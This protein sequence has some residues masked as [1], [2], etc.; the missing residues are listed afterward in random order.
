MWNILPGFFLQ[1]RRAEVSGQHLEE[2][3]PVSAL[4]DRELLQ[5][6]LSES[7]RQESGPLPEEEEKPGGGEQ[8]AIVPTRDEGRKTG[9][10]KFPSLAS[11][12]EEAETVGG[13]PRGCRQRQNRLREGPALGGRPRR[14]SRLEIQASVGR[15]LPTEESGQDY[16]RGSPGVPRVCRPEGVVGQKGGRCFSVHRSGTEQIQKKAEY[17]RGRTHGEDY[18]GAIKADYG[19]LELSQESAVFRTRKKPHRCCLDQKGSGLRG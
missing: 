4:G 9:K 2:L 16:S 3:V 8:R 5:L 19:P 12:P 15:V 6:G 11:R 18:L 14:E 1:G 13:I 10:Q 7:G 17:Y